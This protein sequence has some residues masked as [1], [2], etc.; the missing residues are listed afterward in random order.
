MLKLKLQYIGC[1]MWRADSEKILILG[2]IEDGRRRGRQRMR[3]L[4][5]ITDSMDMSLSL[6]W[7]LVMDRKVWH[8]AVH[9]ITKSQIWLSDWTKLNL[10]VFLRPWIL[11]GLPFPSPSDH[12]DP[13]SH[14]AGS[15]LSSEPLGKT[16]SKNEEAQTGPDNPWFMWSALSFHVLF[17]TKW[18]CLS[19]LSFPQ[20]VPE[21]KTSEKIKRREIGLRNSF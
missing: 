5:G 18:P 19:A 3:W 4:D 14:T 12:A 1:L 17:R 8:A 10:T 9:G 16:L 13:G 20:T 11:N 6:P 2:K 15:F 7:Q 21:L